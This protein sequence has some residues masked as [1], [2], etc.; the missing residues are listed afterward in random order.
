STLLR[1]QDSCFPSVDRYFGATGSLAVAVTSVF[2]WSEDCRSISGVGKFD[3][4]FTEFLLRLQEFRRVESCSS[5]VTKVSSWFITETY[6]TKV[7]LPPLIPTSKI[8]A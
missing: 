7:L 8:R 2:G 1:L 3:R 4:K 5:T 6:K